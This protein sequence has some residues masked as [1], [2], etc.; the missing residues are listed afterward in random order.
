MFNTNDLFLALPRAIHSISATTLLNFCLKM[1]K[2]ICTTTAFIEITCICVYIHVCICL[3]VWYSHSDAQ[4][5]TCIRSMEKQDLH[6][7]L[8]RSEYASYFQP[9]VTD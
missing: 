8:R 7:Y 5:F 2:I 3:S 6:Q 4:E 9:K 1:N